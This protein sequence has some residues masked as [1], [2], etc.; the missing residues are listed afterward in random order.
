M[1][2][3]TFTLLDDGCGEILFGRTAE[4]K[5]N[6]PNIVHRA[7]KIKFEE[8]N[9]LPQLLCFVLFCFSTSQTVPG[10]DCSN[11]MPS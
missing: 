9:P 10:V 3:C 11:N 4:S 6:P 7:V 8:T 2:N 1:A 5:F